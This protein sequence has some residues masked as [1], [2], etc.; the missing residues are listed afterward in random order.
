[1]DNSCQSIV[2]YGVSLNNEHAKIRFPADGWY[3]LKA[4][5]GENLEVGV[6]EDILALTIQNRRPRTLRFYYNRCSGSFQIFRQILRNRYK[7]NMLNR[8]GPVAQLVRAAD[9]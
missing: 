8:V 3:R 6:F 5:D 2:R 9:S 7:I 1:M 4:L